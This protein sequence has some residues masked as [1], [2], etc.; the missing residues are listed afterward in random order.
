MLGFDEG[1]AKAAVTQTTSGLVIILNVKQTSSH[2]L[3]LD[4]FLMFFSLVMGNISIEHFPIK[5]FYSVLLSAHTVLHT[6]RWRG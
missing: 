4:F 3:Y 6:H 2:S 1:V 5:A